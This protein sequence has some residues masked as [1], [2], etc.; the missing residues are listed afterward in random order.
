MNTLSERITFLL[1]FKSVSKA[2]LAKAC[3]VK[4]PSVSN[5]VDGRTKKLE[6]ESLVRASIFFACNPLWLATGIGEPFAKVG[7]FYLENLSNS[8][9]HFDVLDVKSACGAGY[10]NDD[11]PVVI[12]RLEMPLHVAE[13]LVGHV[14]RSSHIKIVTAH[15]DSM[16]PTI[17]PDDLLFIDTSCKEVRG[18]G[19]YLIIH[20][21]GLLC[22]RIQKVGKTLQITSDNK[23]Y[24]PWD[25]SDRDK[26]TFI[27]G[28]VICAHRMNFIKF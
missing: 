4:P 23:V 11:H 9:A 10:A 5:W 2:E 28:K 7:D 13:K 24:A 6:G 14:N 21:G 22:K 16:T 26:D 20:A 18:D 19:I 1:E 17:E 27:V 3:G 8:Y 25:W 15:S 12:S